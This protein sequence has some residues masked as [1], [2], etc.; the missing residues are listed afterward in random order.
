M[1]QEQQQ[2]NDQASRD[3]QTAH[4]ILKEFR[5]LH[6]E[7]YD[8]RVQSLVLSTEQYLE[9]FAGSGEESLGASDKMAIARM[10][11]EQLEVVFERDHPK[12]ARIIY[13]A[14]FYKRLLHLAL[15]VIIGLYL[16]GSCNG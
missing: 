10:L 4:R 1:K 11:F 16:E 9:P 2:R 6:S 8:E 15:G 5:V 12:L 3:A 14:I 13:L 7:N